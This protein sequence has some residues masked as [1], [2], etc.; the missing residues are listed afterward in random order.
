MIQQVEYIEQD[1][2]VEALAYVS[3]P[4]APWN[5][6]RISH[7]ANGATSYVYDSSGGAGTCSYIIDT[8]IDPSHPVRPYLPPLL[9]SSSKS[10][11]PIPT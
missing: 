5:L 9:A 7:R 8:G 11:L 3:Q 1:A 4:S 2:V 6:A 10:K